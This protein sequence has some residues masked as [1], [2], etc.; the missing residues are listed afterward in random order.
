MRTL[1][2]LQACVG[3]EYNQNCLFDAIGGC[4]RRCFAVDSLGP[5]CSNLTH[6]NGLGPSCSMLT[7][8]T[9]FAVPTLADPSSSLVYRFDLRGLCHD[10]GYVA[11]LPDPYG[12][13]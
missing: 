8:R 3:F 1:H 9:D 11:L 10:G 5:S 6:R 13:V 7:H 4:E 2:P 12:F